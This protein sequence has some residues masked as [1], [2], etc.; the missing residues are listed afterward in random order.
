MHTEELTALK[1]SVI[2]H[3]YFAGWRRSGVHGLQDCAE[4]GRSRA[5]PRGVNDGAD[6][7]FALGGPH[8]A[9]AVGD[10]ALD[11]GGSQ[12]ALAGVVCNVDGAG[13]SDKRQE[14]L[15]RPSELALD[16][17]GQITL[18]RRLQDISQASLQGSSFRRK[19]R[20]RKGRDRAG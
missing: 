6:G 16:V 7:C 10:L 12:G 19:G 5:E 17:A 18:G 8:R 2:T 20:G 9:I 11:N 1:E 4:G 15:A 13:E 3:A 14:L